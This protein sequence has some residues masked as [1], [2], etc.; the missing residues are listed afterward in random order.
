MT[1]EFQALGLSV[2]LGLVQVLLA[3][4]FAIR[5]RGLAWAF[6]SREEPMPPLKGL[7]GRLDRAFYNFMETFPLFAALVLVCNSLGVHS[8]LTLWGAG[9]YLW[10]RVIYLPV[11]MAGI[12]VLRTLTWFVSVAGMVLLVVAIF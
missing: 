3:A 1:T 11:Y 12:K 5:E 10:A 8:S 7:A 4:C 2:I 6:S 9:L